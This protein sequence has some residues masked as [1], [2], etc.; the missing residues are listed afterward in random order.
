[1]EIKEFSIRLPVDMYNAIKKE[2][3]NHKRSLNMQ[4]LDMLEKTATEEE[5]KEK[6]AAG[7]TK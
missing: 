6:E 7:A 4:I 1:M 3:G 5:I 2:A